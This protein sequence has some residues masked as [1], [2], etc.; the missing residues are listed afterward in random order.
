MKK[1]IIVLTLTLLLLP[2]LVSTVVADGCYMPPPGYWVRP[3]QQSAVIFYEDNTETLIVTSGYEGNTED[4]VWIIPTPNWPLVNKANQQ[5]FTDIASLATPP[6]DSG[7]LWTAFSYTAAGD[8]YRGVNIL[9]T[10]HV[11]YYEVITLNATN[12]SE[13]ER[14]LNDFNYTYPKNQTNVLDFYINK[15]W[16]FTTLRINPDYQKDEETINDLVSG[17]PTPVKLEFESDEIVFPLKISTI[18]FQ[19]PSI[20]KFGPAEE[21]SI[22]TTRSDTNG[23]IWTKQNDG[24]WII[25]DKN[26]YG[27]W[28]ETGKGGRYPTGNIGYNGTRVGSGVVDTWLGGTDY[29]HSNYYRDDW[30]EVQIFVISNN[31]QELSNTGTAPRKQGE[32]SSHYMNSVYANWITK[33]QIESLGKEKEFASLIQ[34][35]KDKYFLTSIYLTYDRNSIIDDVVLKDAPDNEIFPQKV[36][37]ITKFV[38]T[39]MS[40]AIF[41]LGWAIT[42]GLILIAG[43]LF[44]FLSK[45]RAVRIFGLILEIICFVLTGLFTIALA[46][47]IGPGIFIPGFIAIAIIIFV[48][49][50]QI[51]K[52]K[53]SKQSS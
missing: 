21:E 8:A 4:L 52:K 18:E 31:K 25:E 26:M 3:G 43:A 35:K 15:G 17:H 36:S 34:P 41:L 9:E 16:Y 38:E 28:V 33:E 19:D 39:L 32:I 53:F 2:L 24:M 27:E 22:G 42:L 23:Y 45:S 14:W 29:H 51:K 20:G 5:I 30:V 10:K 46:L 11:D 40:V 48:V 7:G 13:L 12:S 44:T 50:I 49:S 47:F 1:R 6:R 37:S